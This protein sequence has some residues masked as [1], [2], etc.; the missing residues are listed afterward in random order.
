MK[1][2][3]RSSFKR[4]HPASGTL[5]YAFANPY[6]PSPYVKGIV[7]DFRHSPTAPAENAIAADR[8]DAIDRYRTT[9]PDAEKGV[10]GAL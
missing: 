5:S 1:R 2:F 10:T 4:T 7:K 9:N 8:N 3:T 6:P